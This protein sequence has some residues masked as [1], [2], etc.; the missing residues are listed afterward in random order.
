[1]EEAHGPF[2]I[3]IITTATTPRTTCF[4]RLCSFS[5]AFRTA[6]VGPRS[7]H[8]TTSTADRPRRRAGSGGSNTTQDAI[9]RSF[10]F[11]DRR[12]RRKIA[13]AE[14][15]VC[16]DNERCPQSRST[17][18]RRHVGLARQP[19]CQGAT[20]QS[21][22][23]AMLKPEWVLEGSTTTFCV[24][25]PGTWLKSVVHNTMILRRRRGLRQSPR[26]PFAPRLRLATSL[27]PAIRLPALTTP[28][29]CI[30]KPNCTA[31]IC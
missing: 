31:R 4:V 27:L 17:H 7:A 20:T 6:V 23:V 8:W 29:S 21:V 3:R 10:P 2:R 5:R 11:R 24:V 25:A 1:M 28:S 9:G 13:E 16:S 12:V 30:R 18:P 14:N 19:G 15:C 26:A 22:V